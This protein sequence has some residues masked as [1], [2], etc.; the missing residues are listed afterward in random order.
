MKK[1]IAMLLALVMVIGLVACG[2]DTPETTAP[3]AGCESPPADTTAP[4]EAGTI[5][6]AAIGTAYGS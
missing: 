6:V 1:L 2:N 4:G 5:K 3:V